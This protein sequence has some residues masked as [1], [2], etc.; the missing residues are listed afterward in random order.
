[1]SELPKRLGS[2][3]NALHPDLMTPAER[4]D[5]IAEILAAGILRLRARLRAPR[6]STTEQ[7]RVD[8]SPRRSGH[9]RPSV[10]GDEDM[11]DSIAAQV[12]ALPKT[13]TPEL[14]QM[15]RELFDKEPPGFSRNY[16]ISRLAYRIQ[17]LAY[18]GLKPA[19]RARL[20]ALADALDPKAARKRM[21][22]GPVVGTQLIREWRG[23]EHKVTVLADGFEWEGRRYKSLSAVARAITGTRWNGLTFFGMKRHGGGT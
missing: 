20:D 18:G 13:P 1:M 22:N 19:T 2:A 17:E 7:V 21:V 23:V 3:T 8:F 16:L 4:L 9:V 15:W 10:N 12:A 6:G 14:K 11:T 5:E